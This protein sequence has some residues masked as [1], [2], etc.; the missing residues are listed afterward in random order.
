MP[1]Q[2]IINA[3]DF[4]AASSINTAVIKARQR[5][6]LTSA[7]LM[8]TGQAFSEA[9]SIAKDD[10]GLAVGLHLSL[11]QTKS[12]LPIHLI[13][14]LVNNNSYFARS[15]I[16]A[17]FSYYFNPRIRNALRLEI[18]AQFQLFAET[19]IP[20]S[21]VDGH[22]HL[23]AHPAVLPIVIEL[24][25]Q[26]GAS[27]IRIPYDP[28]LANMR[29]NY[30][31]FAPKFC[32][33]M[34]HGYLTRVCRRL[35]RDGDLACCDIAIGALMSGAMNDDYVIKML[36]L[37][38]CG[39]TEIYFHPSEIRYDKYGPNPSD[40]QALVSPK[41]KKFIIDNGYELTNYPSLKRKQAEAISEHS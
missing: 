6:V 25:A 11:S 5:G 17:A 23:H 30:S 24:A 41:L 21:H 34:G 39:Y 28:F 26:Y 8:V 14:G 18:E 37:V 2:L 32:V 9:V 31:N 19:G 13:P 20:M 1:I 3:D 12:A 10:P 38:N 22:Q 36:Q 7:S 35:L 15:P 4:G 16:I 33:A 27:G 40:L 29:V